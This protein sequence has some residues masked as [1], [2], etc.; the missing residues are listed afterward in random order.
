MQDSKNMAV[1][2]LE[3]DGDTISRKMAIDEVKRLHDVAWANWKETRISANT[4]IDALK[5]LPSAQPH[6][7][8]CSERLPNED[9]EVLV[10]SNSGIF[11]AELS[12]ER[13]KT[14]YWFEAVEGKSL[15]N[16]TAWMPLPKP[17]GG[18]SDETN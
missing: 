9:E 12:K 10:T 14:I 7:I 2:A 5:D 15:H 17:Y 13:D 11:I 16:V 1:R 18:E 4:M 8:P 6:W 3:G